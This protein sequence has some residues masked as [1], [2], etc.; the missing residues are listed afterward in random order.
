MSWIKDVKEELN[1]LDISK[2]SLRN[3]GLLVGGIF[4]LLGLW[5]YYRSQSPLGIVFFVIG[6]LLLLFGLVSPNSLSQ[7]FKIWMGLAF[8]L[9]WLMSRVLLTILFYFVITPIGFVAK[10]VGKDFLDINYK[11]KR[12]SYWII[13]S[14][15]KKVDY[16]KM[17]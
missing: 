14:I 4:F 13:R 9:G 8:A 7:V 10:V 3:F 11:M 6:A 5:I 2:K 1:A 17:F 15:D 12:E 16:T